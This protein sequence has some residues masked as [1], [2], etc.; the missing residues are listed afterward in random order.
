MVLSSWNKRWLCAK[1][2]NIKYMYVFF[3]NIDGFVHKEFILPGQTVNKVFYRGVL[4]RLRGDMR[5]KR[6]E[7]WHINDWVLH[8]DNAWPHTACIVQ[9]FL[10][11]NKWKLLHTHRTRQT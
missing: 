11:K 7:K 10:A 3:S 9:E 2:V 4:R 8:H 5:S 1:S 6:P